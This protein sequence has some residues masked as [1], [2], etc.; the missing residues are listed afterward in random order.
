VEGRVLPLTPALEM[1]EGVR[2]DAA[3]LKTLAGMV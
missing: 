2:D 1:P 3:V